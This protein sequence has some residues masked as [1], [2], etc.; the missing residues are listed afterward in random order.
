MLRTIR[1]LV[2]SLAAVPLIAGAALAQGSTTPL[3]RALAVQDSAPQERRVEA[4]R[5]VEDALLDSTLY[6]VRLPGA[7]QGSRFLV[8]RQGDLPVLSGFDTPERLLRWAEASFTEEQREPMGEF[9]G[10]AGG[11]LVLLDQQMGGEAVLYINA[12]YDQPLVID[13]VFFRF[14]AARARQARQDLPLAQGE[15]APATPLERHAHAR[16]QPDGTVEVASEDLR[17]LVDGQLFYV[18]LYAQAPADAVQ[19][20]PQ[21]DNAGSGGGDRLALEGETR[22][23]GSQV[24]RLAVFDRRELADGYAQAFEAQHGTPLRYRVMRGIDLM[25]A[26]P[27]NIPVAIN[28]GSSYMLVIAP[29]G[30][31]SGAATD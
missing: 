4:R 21:Q 30:E 3:D 26:L 28:P 19:S 15:P 12:S 13:P 11:F 22:P 27:A 18:P 24:Y 8:G 6:F 14:L 1:T 2:A 20:L 7:E 5:A 10:L 9:S 31:S 16:A 29:D 25:Q 17:Y 23:D